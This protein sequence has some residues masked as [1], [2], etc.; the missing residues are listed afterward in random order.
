MKKLLVIAIGAALF[1][2]CTKEGL[3]GEATLVVKPAHHGLPILSTAAYQ[4]SVF[5]KFNT[6][7]APS[8]PTTEYDLLVVGTVGEDHIHVEGLEHGDYYVYCTGWDT[9]IN[10]RVTGGIPVTI[11]RKERKDEIVVDVP[12]TE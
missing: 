12:I 9:S 7:D 10:M 6:L 8:S 5:V 4:D 3:G 2:S 1:Y 11:K